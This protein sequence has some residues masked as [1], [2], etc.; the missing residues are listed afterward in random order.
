M[1]PVPEDDGRTRSTEVGSS[2]APRP[3]PPT[4]ASAT[5]CVVFAVT[6]PGRS[7]TSQRLRLRRREGDG[8]LQARQEGEQAGHARLGHRRGRDGATASSPTRICSASVAK[9]SFR[10]SR[11]S[12]V[13]ASRSPPWVGGS[14]E[15]AYETA[16]AYSK[17][18]EQFG[19]A[20]RRR[21]RR[22]SSISPRWRPRIA[23]QRGA[24]PGCRGPP[25]G[26]RAGRSRDMAARGEAVLR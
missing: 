12:T 8:R 14:L 22:S 7:A 18:R 11:F 23:C 26:P 20:D 5:I 9:G 21:S 3:S 15:G 17:E 6:D 16:L 10:R 25:D 1:P 19:Q 24:D 4:A 2:T 13:G